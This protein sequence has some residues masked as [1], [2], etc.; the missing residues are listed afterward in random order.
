MKLSTRGRYGTRAMLDLAVNAKANSAVTLKEIAQRQDISLTYLEHL[1]GPLID[2]GLIRSIRGSKGGI[3]LAKSAR[4][5]TIKDIVGVLEGPTAPVECLEHANICP[6][7][8]PVLLR[9][10]GM[11]LVKLLIRYWTLKLSRIWL[12]AKRLEAFQV[13]CTTYKINWSSE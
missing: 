4:D 8:V 13:K 9:K 11:K 1:V 12:N 6:D 3:T 5:I 2:A 7:P 10:F